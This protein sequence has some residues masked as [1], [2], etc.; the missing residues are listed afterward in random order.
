VVGKQFGGRSEE[1][2]TRGGSRR[3]RGS[4][5]GNQRFLDGGAVEGAGGDVCEVG[6][7]RGRWCRAMLIRPRKREADGGE[8][9]GVC[10]PSTRL[11]DVGTY[12]AKSQSARG[13]RQ[14]AA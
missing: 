3:Q 14:P 7:F 4:A 2:L 1:G 12:S 8:L 10:R 9:A 5:M 13:W 11:M 6:Q